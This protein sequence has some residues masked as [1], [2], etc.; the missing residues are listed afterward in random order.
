MLKDLEKEEMKP[1]TLKVGKF[2][3]L[4]LKKS[5]TIIDM[6]DTF[7]HLSDKEYGISGAEPLC[8]YLFE[9]VNIPGKAKD[10][11]IT[12]WLKLNN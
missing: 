2:D 8:T 3:V 10:D 7:L 5:D 6:V 4:N 9:M 1:K 12:M 11:L